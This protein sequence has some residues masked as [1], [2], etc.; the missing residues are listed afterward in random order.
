M[1]DDDDAPS[2]R[3]TVFNRRRLLATTAGAAVV[4]V[5]SAA[6]EA[7][8]S[9]QT[10]DNLPEQ[11]SPR[12]AACTYVN[13]LAADDRA[14]ANAVIASD[15][16]LDPWS[17]RGFAWV[18]SFDIEYVGFETVKERSDGIVGDIAL[19]IAGNDG[20]VR[21]R[22]RETE[23]GWRIWEAIDGLRSTGDS[24]EAARSVAEAYVT[25][26]DAGN[27]GAVNELIAD[28]GELS[29]WSRREFGWVG[30]FDF[31]FVGFETVR[32]EGDEVVA[33][34]DLAIDGNEETV[35]YRFRESSDGSVEL[36]AAVGGV[37]TT[38]EVS[39][40]AAANA[41]IDALDD[42]TRR[43][44]ND[45]IADGGDLSPWAEDDF[46]WVRPFDVKLAEFDPTRRRDTAVIADLSVRLGG[47]TEPVSYE[48]RRT[49]NGWKLWDGVDPIR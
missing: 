7:T 39:A 19:R 12:H 23:R 29:A 8:P 1:S 26:L 47:S 44:A 33:D 22:F 5:G 20:T 30:A 48:F 27:R 18:G 41:Y 14:L 38:G 13:A 17:Q 45:L 40:E 35:R 16:R 21:Y 43:E 34:I 6:S 24:N 37:R 3:R 10:G 2:D 15:G 9:G 31:E 46:E 28:D 4:P 49:D 36:W 11:T 32:T 42:G 25:A